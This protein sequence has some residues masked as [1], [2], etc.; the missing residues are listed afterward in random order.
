MI[1]HDVIQGS[2]EWLR[3]RAGV[4]TASRFD[5][6]L[7]PGGAPSKSAQGYLYELLAERMLGAPVTQVV[8]TWMDRGSQTEAEAVAYYEL[9]SEL[10]T[11]KVGFVTNDAGT[12]GASPD[13]LVGDDG[14]LEIKVPKEGN[15]VG[16]LLTG[17][18]GDKYKPQLMGQLWVTG[19]AW[20]DIMS[21]HPEMPPALIRVERDAGYIDTLSRAVTAF[22]AELERV[23]VDARERGWIRATA[24]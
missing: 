19:R 10:D 16:Y 23:S 22:S 21:Y 8:S 20:V 15:H 17:S 2:S 1:V 11:V 18:V 12:V 9:M 7:T 14:L 4:P 5:D 24:S 13:R 6:I 3:L